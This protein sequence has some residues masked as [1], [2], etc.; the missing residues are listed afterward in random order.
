MKKDKMTFYIFI[1]I[2]VGGL[3]FVVFSDSGL[4]KYGKLRS[5]LNTLKD[6]LHTLNENIKSLEAEIDSLEKKIPAKIERV[7]R[8]KFEMSRPGEKKIKYQIVP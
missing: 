2:V 5:E 3:F 1:V 6:S 7:A 8:E 4:L